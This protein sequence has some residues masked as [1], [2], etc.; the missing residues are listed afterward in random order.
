M[1]TFTKFV[2][3]PLEV[4]KEVKAPPLTVHPR[5]ERVKVEKMLSKKKKNG[6]HKRLLQLSLARINGY[7]EHGHIAAPNGTFMPNTNISTLIQYAL[8]KTGEAPPGARTFVD[9]LAIAGVKPH[10][11]K[12]LNVKR[13]L[14]RLALPMPFMYKQHD[15]SQ[16]KFKRP[17]YWVG[18][19]VRTYP[20]DSMRPVT[21]N[22]FKEELMDDFDTDLTPL[23]ESTSESVLERNPESVFASTPRLPFE[24]PQKPELLT[25]K[26]EETLYETLINAI[27]IGIKED[28]ADDGG[29]VTMYETPRRSK[30]KTK[31][32]VRFTPSK[33]K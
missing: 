17:T 19:K 26:E 20:G 9:L 6:N 28:E 16:R 25:P 31:R 3:M 12:N 15:I 23:F 4:E 13:L 32:T 8:N 10:D 7:N 2:A 30:R 14:Q 5:I 29:M 18:G 24:T 21:D 27:D 11:V 33:H 1:N 22:P